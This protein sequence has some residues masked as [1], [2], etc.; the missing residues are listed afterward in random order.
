LRPGSAGANSKECT[1]G[2]LEGVTM[3]VGHDL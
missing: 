2:D 3:N 1:A